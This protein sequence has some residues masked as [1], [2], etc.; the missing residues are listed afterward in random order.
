MTDLKAIRGLI[1][2]M[3]G[4][5]LDSMPIWFTIEIDYLKSLGVSPHPDLNKTLRALSGLETAMYFQSEYG[6]R[7]TV[8]EIETERNAMLED[9]YFN[10]APLKDGVLETL[11]AFRERDVRMCIATATDRHLTEPALQR[12]G[13]IDYFERIYTCSEEGSS[14]SSP[15]IYFRAA[16]FLGTN[17]SDTLVVEDALYAMKSAKKAGFPVAAVYDLSYEDRSD[18]IRALVDFYFV[19]MDEMLAFL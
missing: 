17:V 9:F 10:R 19:K 3:D 13:V 5:L 6:V 2:D 1:F 7:K 14:K 16:E 8:F 12:C 11:Q 18:D 4:T 15:D